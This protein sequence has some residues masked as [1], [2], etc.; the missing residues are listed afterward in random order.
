MDIEKDLTIIEIRIKS[1]REKNNYTQNEVAKLMGIS[2]S[3][4]CLWEQGYTNI[5]LKQI[6]SFI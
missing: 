1:L 6:S 2:R 5:S 4:I 3:L